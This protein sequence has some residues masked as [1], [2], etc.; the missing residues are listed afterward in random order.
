MSD[1]QEK[2]SAAIFFGGIMAL[3]GA[4]FLGPYGAI[5]GGIIGAIIGSRK[6]NW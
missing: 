2:N 4:Y 3:I 6:R 5:I 1:K